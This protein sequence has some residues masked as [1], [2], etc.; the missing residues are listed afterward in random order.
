MIKTRK[1]SKHYFKRRTRA[2]ILVSAACLILNFLMVFIGRQKS[3]W[4]EM[5]YSRYFFRGMSWLLNSISNLFPFSLDEVFIGL[6]ILFLVYWILRGIV[7]FF[8]KKFPKGGYYLSKGL[9]I[10]CVNLLLFQL[11]WGLNNYRYPVEE[12]F[13]LEVHQISQDQLEEVYEFLVVK[14]NELRQNLDDMESWTHKEVRDQAYLGYESLAD[15]YSFISPKKVVVK[16]LL[17]SGLFT[18]SGYTG[19][20]LPFFSEANINVKPPVLSLAFTASHEI[21]HFKGFASED[22]ANFLGFLASM[23]NSDFFKYSAVLQMQI[24]VGNSLYKTDK[25]AYR[26]IAGLRNELV[27]DDLQSRRDFWDANI[28]ETAAEAHDKINDAF[29]KANNQPEGIINYS[30]V[31]ELIVFAY[32]KGLIK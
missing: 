25:D 7:C 24:Y 31:S 30:K 29:L 16:P 3:E 13:D 19:I 11:L 8:M 9:A 17:I 14:G 6:E 4:I 28:I 12:L 26:A 21:G 23:E 27:L 32:E 2:F 22:E 15:T 5:F 10:L 20:Y 18:R 1:Q